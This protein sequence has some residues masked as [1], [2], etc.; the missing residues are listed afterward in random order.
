M[1]LGQG[2]TASEEAQRDEHVAEMTKNK[3]R[4]M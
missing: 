3:D 4:R 1:T 2:V